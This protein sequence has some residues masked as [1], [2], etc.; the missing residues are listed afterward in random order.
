MA[1]KTVRQVEE[2]IEYDELGAEHFRELHHNNLRDAEV[3]HAARHMDIEKR[4][5]AVAALKKGQPGLSDTFVKQQIAQLENQ[6]EAFR[7]TLVELSENI[8]YHK[9]ALR[10]L[11]APAPDEP[12]S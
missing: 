2:T 7:V 5:R 9:E 11:P 4:R 12:E 6:I 10:K 3:Q 1:G 8:A